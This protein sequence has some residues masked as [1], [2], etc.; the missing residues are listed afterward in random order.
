MRQSWILLIVLSLSLSACGTLKI[1]FEMAPPQIPDEPVGATSEATAEPGL[2]LRSS[3]EEIRRAMLESA[4]TWQSIWMDGTFIGYPMEGS[5]T[6]GP[7][8]RE[9]VWI[10]L[11]TSHF[12]LVSGFVDGPMEKFKVSD[13][14]AVLE[15]NLQTGQSQSTPLPDLGL[16]KQFVPAYQPGSVYPQPL[17][18]QMGTTLSLMAFPSDF[19]QSE[20][21]FKPLAKE[22]VAD[23]ETLVV[24]W[25]YASND[26]PSWRMWLDTK[27]AVIL[28]MQNFGKEGAAT[29]QSETIVNQVI[30]NA[31]FADSLFRAPA[32]PPEFSDVAGNPVTSTEPVPTASSDPDPLREVYFFVSDHND[33]RETTQLVSVPGSCAAGLRL[34]P[35][36]E[37]ISPPFGLDF[38]LTHLVWSPS[39]DAAAFSYPVGDGFRYGLFLFDPGTQ[40]WNSLAEFNFID[41]PVWSPDGNWL[42][43][44]VQDGDG[45]EEI[46]AVRRD[47]SQLTNLSASENLAS[48]GHPYMLNGWI[49]NNV[50]LRGRGNAM[51]YLVRVED[52]LVRPLFD[53]PWA[54]SD[55]IPSPDGYF[56]AYAEAAEQ[57]TVLKLLTPNGSTAR[58]LTSFQNASIF[59]I[60]WSPDGTSLA[61]VTGTGDPAHG[62]DVYVIGQDGR[63]LQQIYHSDFASIND[64]V[65]SPDGRYLLFQDDD[66]AGRHIFI[67]DLSTPQQ[68]MLQ[69]PNLPLDWWWLAPSWRK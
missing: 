35:E 5:V 18:G 40:T 27:T 11:P 22:L 66:A 67:I 6:P 61:F 43:F 32:S 54:K 42:A 50:I 29:I 1:S 21:T 19:A 4:T 17:W 46:F 48:E 62:Q 64:L 44:R 39:G 14:I 57:N 26:F 69:V 7:V 51:V 63:N 12:R 49:S 25:T 68:R 33:G 45:S 24:E 3:S 55:L 9:Q 36:V 8:L 41:P 23:R 13:G 37:M 60:V 58:D 10:D 53:T 59:P 52:R 16:E 2:S 30:Y 47:G 34:C 28:K 20:G 15:M 31:S 38:G 65:Y 56:L